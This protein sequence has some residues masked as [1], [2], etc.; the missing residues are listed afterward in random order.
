[1]T[2][3]GTVR[4]GFLHHVRDHNMVP[5]AGHLPCITFRQYIFH[6]IRENVFLPFGHKSSSMLVERA[7]SI[8]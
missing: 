3:R 5:P 6:G 2:G 8:L 7:G 1:M 4:V